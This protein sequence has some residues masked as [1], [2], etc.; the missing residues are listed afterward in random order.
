MEGHH[1]ALTGGHAEGAVPK[2]SMSATT[3][4]IGAI[5]TLDSTVVRSNIPSVDNGDVFR[6]L[7]EAAAKVG[8]SHAELENIV[9]NLNTHV[10]QQSVEIEGLRR[11]NKALSDKLEDYL[12]VAA[13][14]Q[15]RSIERETAIVRETE[16]QHAKRLTDDMWSRTTEALSEGRGREHKLETMIRNASEYATRLQGQVES[17]NEV[18]RNAMYEMSKRMLRLSQQ[19][20]AANVRQLLTANQ[21]LLGVLFF[22]KWQRYARSR[23]GIATMTSDSAFMLATRYLTTWFRFKAK[24]AQ[25]K[26]AIAYLLRTNVSRFMISH[27][28]LWRTFAQSKRARRI[29]KAQHQSNVCGQLSLKTSQVIRRDTFQKWLVWARHHRRN[30]GSL[31]LVRQLGAAVVRD[32][33]RRVF[34]LW[35]LYAKQQSH[36]RKDLRSL[37]RQNLSLIAKTFFQKWVRWSH[38]GQLALAV[39]RSA[40]PLRR[41]V[42]S[43]SMEV[44]ELRDMLHALLERH[45]GLG[46]VVEL[47]ARSKLAIKAVKPSSLIGAPNATTL[48]NQTISGNVS[49]IVS[50][51]PSERATAHHPPHQHHFM[52]PE[53]YQSQT[54]LTKTNGEAQPLGQP[55]KPVAITS[56]PRRPSMANSDILGSRV[57]TERP[58]HG[59]GGAARHL[60]QQQQQFLQQLSHPPEQWPGKDPIRSAIDE[61]LV[62]RPLTQQIVT[63]PAPHRGGQDKALDS[64]NKAPQE[65]FRQV[66]PQQAG[67]SPGFR[68]LT[69]NPPQIV[70]SQSTDSS[71]N[72]SISGLG[73]T[74]PVV[75]PPPL[76]RPGLLDRS[77]NGKLTPNSPTNAI[78]G[79]FSIS[80]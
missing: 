29:D 70:R 59:V 40:A 23:A 33:R 63:G 51:S 7:F 58:Q 42:A 65:P 45:E 25:Y 6:A 76:Y 57:L 35:C 19:A 66:S 26:A 62:Y 17:S 16:R 43:L 71:V 37:Q 32:H 22:K 31:H 28:N 41:Q 10:A 21:K 73:A 77:H 72:Y 50:S 60:Y 46:S 47:V 30:K 69:H 52:G 12:A 64:A 44:N 53:H 34:A 11:E 3:E 20:G 14:V 61:V 15:A 78:P 18:L 4:A 68:S 13:A 5:S 54:P 80:Q 2:H 9:R 48:Q 75:S 38:K 24:R 56:P 49:N 8:L 67:R 74:Q 55:V 27:L 39:E 36:R 79:R 1:S